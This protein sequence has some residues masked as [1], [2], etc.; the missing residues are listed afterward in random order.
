MASDT[1]RQAQA[2][3]ALRH[4]SQEE[5]SVRNASERTSLLR[6]EPDQPPNGVVNDT[7]VTAAVVG[8]DGSAEE[9]TVLY[10]E[11]SFGKLALIMGTTWIGVFLGAVD[12]TIIATLSAPIASEF[13]SLR[14]LSWLATAYLISNAACQPIS[15]R[16]TDIFGRGPGLVFSNVVF[17]AGNLICG[18]AQD[19]KTMIFGRVV[20]G[21]GGGGLMSISTFVGSDLVPLRSRGIVQGI[22]N[23]CYGSGAMMGGLFGGLVNDHTT[24]GWRLAFLVQVPPVLLSAVAVHF[25][26]KVPPK[27]SDKSYLARIDF[28]GVFLTTLFLTLL[29]L[30]LNSGGNQVPW[31]HPLPLTTIPLSIVLFGVFLWWEGRARQPIIPVRLLMSRTVLAACAANMLSTMVVVTLLFYVPLFMQVMG[32]SATD[33]GLRLLP[34]PVGVSF[35]SVLAGYMMKRTGRFVTLGILSMITIITGI[36]FFTLMD[37]TSSVWLSSAAFFLIGG[38][39]GA[40]LTTTLLACIAA[41]D[42]SQQ[43]VVTSATYLARSLG[44]T[45]GITIGSAVYQN[46]LQARLWDRFGGQPNAADEIRRIRD[47]LAELRHLPPGWYDGVMDSFM[48]AFRGVWLTMLGLAVAG[49][50]CVSLMRHHTLHSTLDRQ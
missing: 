3:I 44:G 10:K 6:P 25:L 26:V 33:A 28:M 43:A 46:I 40:L 13:K 41:V 35:M 14:L 29:L 27:Q 39:Y 22:G 17:A 8:I 38:G 19:E 48:D 45:V 21:I 50:A 32:D 4:D 15:G 34:S 20:A 9:Q 36:I 1:K 16:L 11:E 12:S 47:D 5:A 30:G 2:K 42:H 7:S 24:L 37:R 18:L 31:T 49:L 23:I